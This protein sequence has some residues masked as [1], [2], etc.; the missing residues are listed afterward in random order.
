MLRRMRGYARLL[1][2]R[3]VWRHAARMVAAALIADAATTAFGLPEGYW[4][5]ITCLVVVQA[6]LGATVTAGLS[7]LA[8]TIAGGAWAAAVTFPDFPM[9]ATL[10]VLLVVGPPSV[11]AASSATFRLAPVTA[12]VVALGH[13]SAPTID[14]AAARVAEICLGTVIGVLAGMFILPGRAVRLLPDSA[15]Q[16]LRLLGELAAAYLTGAPPD[17][18]DLLSDRIRV[19]L[20]RVD[21]Q[22]GES[23]REMSLHLG[24]RQDLEALVRTLRRLRGD[25]IVLARAM[26]AEPAEPHGPTD[27]AELARTVMAIF[28]AT[29]D[30]LSAGLAP[31]ALLELDAAT[32]PAQTPLGFALLVL[33]R[34]LAEMGDRI[35]ERRR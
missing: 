7:R 27:H 5:I 9:P 15:A 2:G 17:Q 25:V 30:A 19:A 20:A 26:N 8:G 14:L 1:P 4:A 31:P 10:R 24:R 32:V 28:A 33:R 22:L 6:S 12:A 34:D 23:R 16:G 18:T 35:A 21:A 3:P 13:A 29:A 11:L